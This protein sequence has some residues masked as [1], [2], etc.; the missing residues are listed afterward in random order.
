MRA[1]AVGPASPQRS[2]GAEQAARSEGVNCRSLRFLTATDLARVEGPPLLGDERQMVCQVLDRA[3]DH[4]GDAPVAPVAHHARPLPRPGR[5][6]RQDARDLA[7]AEIE[8]RDFLLDVPLVVRERGLHQIGL[9]AVEGRPILRED[10]LD[11]MGD[12]RVRVGEVADDLQGAPSPGDG[13]RDYL[14]AAIGGQ[15]KNVRRDRESLHFQG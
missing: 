10:S 13:P 7:S 14:L 2:G 4:L 9:D 12:V 3:V 15:K 11:A 1:P 6:G 5:R 8:E